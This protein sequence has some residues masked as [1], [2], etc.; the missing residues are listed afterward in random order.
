MRTPLSPLFLFFKKKK[1]SRVGC[2][3]AT[4]LQI[5]VMDRRI[6]RQHCRIERIA[7]HPNGFILT[8]TG[9]RNGTFVN[10]RKVENGVWTL[11]SEGDE[12]SLGKGLR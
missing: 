10:G 4:L 9:S 3:G 8:D 2:F 7:E 11:L 12:I 1:E 5:S 6:S